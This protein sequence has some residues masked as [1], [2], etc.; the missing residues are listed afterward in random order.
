[1]ISG[2][3]TPD[4]DAD[5]DP[6]GDSWRVG[7][8]GESDRDGEADQGTDEAPVQPT[9]TP[10]VAPDAT[11]EPGATPTQEPVVEP[12]S[13]PAPA[14]EP[15]PVVPE[16]EVEDF[17]PGVELPDIGFPV[18]DPGPLPV[19]PA[20]AAP[21]APET[22][23]VP[24][25]PEPPAPT[26]LDVNP[27]EAPP[28]PTPE[29]PVSL[30]PAGDGAPGGLTVDA[31]GCAS[32]CITTALLHKNIHDAD[33]ELELVT[34]VATTKV[35]WVT[36]PSPLVIDGVLAHLQ[37]PPRAI[38]NTPGTNWNV[39]LPGLQHDTTYR[40]VVSVADQYGNDQLLTTLVTTTSEPVLD[41]AAQGS[42]CQFNCIVSGEVTPL[43]SY[44]QVAL[45][46]EASGPVNFHVAMSASAPFAIDGNPFL[47][48]DV[49]ISTDVTDRTPGRRQG[50]EGRDLVPL[51]HSQ[52]RQYRH[53]VPVVRA[54]RQDRRR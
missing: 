27:V 10:A 9:A 30:A 20:P 12:E 31:V 18:V 28:A 8:G 15:T 1:M 22:P 35:V 49:L 6:D 40:I 11:P 21:V 2:D 19:L 47:P 23:A 29:P 48:S 37:Q 16:D 34:N 52:P 51:W 53:V 46:I 5:S 26:A 32:N 14:Q 4:R 7:D 38:A 13:S 25:L 17:P 41:M 44:D 42:P 36:A 24:E 33:L 50:R 43:S 39:E 54:L 45:R 3:A